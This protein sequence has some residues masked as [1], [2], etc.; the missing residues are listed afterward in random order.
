MN[1]VDVSKTPASLRWDALAEVKWCH[2]L[3]G[4]DNPPYAVGVKY[5]YPV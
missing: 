1:C 3:Y 5:H 4:S 2:K